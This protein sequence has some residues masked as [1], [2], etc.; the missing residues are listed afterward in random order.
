VGDHEA[1]KNDAGH[2]PDHLLPDRGANYREANGPL[3]A[4]PSAQPRE[5]AF[6]ELA[7]GVSLE[8]IEANLLSG[9]PLRQIGQPPRA[10]RAVEL[11]AGPARAH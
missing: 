11:P 9:L 4:R 2:R 6:K 5:S 10:H 1:H 3:F 7:L 8:K